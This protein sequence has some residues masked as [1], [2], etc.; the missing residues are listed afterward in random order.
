MI[1]SE[2]RYLIG[3]R[4]AGSLRSNCGPA[5]TRP[6]YCRFM[7]RLVNNPAKIKQLS[8]WMGLLP[9]GAAIPAENW[10]VG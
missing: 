6:K 1:H 5:A 9:N 7:S 10:T 2:L 4:V 3:A 8:F